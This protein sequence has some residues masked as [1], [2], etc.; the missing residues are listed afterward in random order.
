MW[1]DLGGGGR[2]PDGIC[3]DAED[4]IWIASPGTRECLRVREGGEI[5]DN[6]STGDRLA[7]ACMLGDDDRRTLYVLTSKGLD[8]EK[9]RDLRTGRLERARVDVPGAGLP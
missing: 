6:V 3:L 1:A 5:V 8:P 4:C 9:A 2:F 7:I